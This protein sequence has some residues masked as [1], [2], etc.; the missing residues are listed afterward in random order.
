M[1]LN[2]NYS[3]EELGEVK[4]SI[5]E[6]NCSAERVEFL[7][8]LLEFNGFTVVVVNS[9]P[10]KTAAKPIVPAGTDAPVETTPPAP[11][12]TTFT[13]GVTDLTFNPINGVYNRQLKTEDGKFVTPHYWKQ[14]DKESQDEVWYWKK[15][16]L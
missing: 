12:I 5:I 15:R 11:V 10:P 3:F 8:K 1:A 4:C 9:P 2:A 16:S 6:K 14:I 7:K 13:V